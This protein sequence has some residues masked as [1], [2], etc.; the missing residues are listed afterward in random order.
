MRGQC[1]GGFAYDREFIEGPPHRHAP[2]PLASPQALGRGDCGLQ[3]EAAGEFDRLPVGRR[4][5][6]G[7][8]G[9]T[10]ARPSLPMATAVAYESRPG[11]GARAD[12]NLLKV[13]R[14]NSGNG[15]RGALSDPS[16]PRQ[17]TSPL[18]SS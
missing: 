2:R 4:N 9:L 10:P 5:S 3:L 12:V 18:S 13:M 6:D 11:R 14:Q 8:Q 17:G 15:C 1:R 7:R 16:N